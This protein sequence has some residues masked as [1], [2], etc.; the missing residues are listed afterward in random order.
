MRV[1]LQVLILIVWVAWSFDGVQAVELYQ[2]EAGAIAYHLPTEEAS[3]AYQF[4][5]GEEFKVMGRTEDGWLVVAFSDQ[6]LAYLT[7]DN[8]V[9][10]LGENS[11]DTLSR[12]TVLAL[13]EDG[14]KEVAAAPSPIQIQEE[15]PPEK[16]LSAGENGKRTS[17]EISPCRLPLRIWR[18]SNQGELVIL[19]NGAVWRVRQAEHRTQVE[20]WQPD[21]AISVCRGLLTQTCGAVSV[22]AT[23]VARLDSLDADGPSPEGVIMSQIQS[24]QR[25]SGGQIA[26]R[27]ANEQTWLLDSYNYHFPC[28]STGQAVTLCKTKTGYYLIAESAPDIV[29]SR[30]ILSPSTEDEV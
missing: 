8:A 6:T 14:L 17:G 29:L 25:E 21:A 9:P 10:A 24:E 3:L 30:Q 18:V 28:Y 22:A 12:L 27:L 1:L 4:S 2:S 19:E 11:L 26:L 23:L 5:A 16:S 7:Q 15:T 13:S 20:T